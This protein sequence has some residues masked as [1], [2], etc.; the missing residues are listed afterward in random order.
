MIPKNFKPWVAPTP[1]AF[2]ITAPVKI[3]TYEGRIIHVPGEGIAISDDCCCGPPPPTCMDC[4]TKLLHGDW[5]P[6]TNDEAAHFLFR[7][8]SLT[9]DDYITVKVFGIGEDRLVCDGDKISIHSD[10]IHGEAVED[11]PETPGDETDDGHGEGE[12]NHEPHVWWDR[13]WLFDGIFP[14]VG[15]DGVVYAHGLVQY[16][17]D[18]DVHHIEMS[19]NYTACWSDKGVQ[20]GDIEIGWKNESLGFTLEFEDC[21]RIDTPDCCV[22]THECV[23][24]CFYLPDDAGERSPDGTQIIFWAEAGGVRVR[25]ALDIDPNDRVMYCDES[26]GSVNI[27]IEVIPPPNYNAGKDPKICIEWPGW[28]PTTLPEGPECERPRAEEC[29]DADWTNSISG[30]S[31]AII[32]QAPPC[33][34]DCFESAPTAPLTVTVGLEGSGAAAIEVT[35]DIL[36]P[37]G[38]LC[39][40][41]VHVPCC[42]G[43]IFPAN[44]D[45]SDPDFPMGFEKG[46]PSRIEDLD[47]TYTSGGNSYRTEQVGESEHEFEMRNVAIPGCP[48]KMRPQGSCFWRVPCKVSENGGSPVNVTL[49]VYGPGYIGTDD[50]F[51]DPDTNPDVW[52][53]YSGRWGGGASSGGVNADSGDCHGEI[54]VAKGDGSKDF[55]G[56]FNARGGQPTPEGTRC[57]NG[58]LEE[59]DGAGGWRKVQA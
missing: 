3:R 13:A 19:F 49:I 40:C 16:A 23:D 41:R 26:G 20:Y 44:G 47:I 48:T 54:P 39:C 15:A 50:M 30:Y 42:R 25:L 22:S 4:C 35:T 10:Y 45:P 1:S 31:S 18:V 34:H 7:V 51:G 36:E 59:P 24:C 17:W 55:S 46:G 32:Y 57:F 2:T 12:P 14:G 21:E 58:W 43:C 33:E 6:A 27:N 56:S 37:C 9:S 11:D 5:V 8:D 53:V 38:G 29:D 52:Q 28:W